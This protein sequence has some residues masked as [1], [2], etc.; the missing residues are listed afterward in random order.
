MVFVFVLMFDINDF[1]V[2][3][4]V[5]VLCFNNIGL[6]LGS[7]E[8]FLFF[9]LFLKFFFLFVM[10]VGCLEIYFVLLMFIFKIWLKL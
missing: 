9:S 5:V 2:V 10:I 3:V 8:I 1:L 7:N 6:F 4:S